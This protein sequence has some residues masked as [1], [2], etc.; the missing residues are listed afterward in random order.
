MRRRRG[1]EGSEELEPGREERS[2]EKAKSSSRIL[3]L[4]EIED[5]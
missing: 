2:R 4:K 1:W 5:H 3:E